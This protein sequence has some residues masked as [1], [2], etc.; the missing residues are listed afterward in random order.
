[1]DVVKAVE[2]YVTKILTLPS[3]MKVLLL[4]SYTVS[5]LSH[6]HT[7]ETTVLIQNYNAD[8]YSLTLIHS[9]DITISSSI[10]H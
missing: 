3:A 2:N 8:T 5:N 9:I 1:M 10:P 6:G 4:D 7:K